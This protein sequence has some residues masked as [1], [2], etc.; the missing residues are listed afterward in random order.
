M[1]HPVLRAVARPVERGQIGSAIVQRLIDDMVETMIEYHGVGLA[2][3]Q[4]HEGLRVFVAMLDT[5]DE[6]AEADRLRSSTPRSAGGGMWW[7]TG[8]AAPVFPT[9]EA[10]C[11]AA[12]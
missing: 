9:S 10:A 7:K 2:A 1:G 4:V 6:D 3:P 5:D 8:R 12:K 11:R